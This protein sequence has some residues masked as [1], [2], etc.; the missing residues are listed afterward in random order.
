M[1]HRNS[2]SK[3]RVPMKKAAALVILLAVLMVPV[4]AFAQQDVVQAK[5]TNLANG[6][7]TIIA[8]VGGIV[9][10]IGVSIGGIKMALGHPDAWAFATKVLIGGALIASSGA[11]VKWISAP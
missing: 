3:R 9:I 1:R 6:I 10:G 7:A 8:V 11:I 2:K 4:F 5:A